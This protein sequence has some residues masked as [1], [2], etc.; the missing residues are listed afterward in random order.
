MVPYDAQLPGRGFRR[1]KRGGVQQ[2]EAVRER[3]VMKQSVLWAAVVSAG[4]LGAGLP[5]AVFGADP[6][7]PEA[8]TVAATPAAPA[9]GGNLRYSITVSKFE[10]QAGWHG[11]WDIGDAWGSV[12]TDALQASGRFIVLGE[13]DMR[14]EAMNEQDL[15][16]SGRTAGGGKTPAIGQMTPAQ[17]LVKGAITHVQ[18]STT[19]GEGGI[20][21]RGIRIGGSKD[22]GEINAT[23]YVVDSRTGQV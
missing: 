6:A 19:G 5:G 21:F 20:G 2:F 22:A 1:P 16:A 17:L 23:V 13:G 10:N 4:M 11:Q 7:G 14:K 8:S 9:A 12:M 15:G 18:D 3:V